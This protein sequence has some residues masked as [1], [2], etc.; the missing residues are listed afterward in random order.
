[1]SLLC[2]GGQLLCIST[3][4]LSGPKQLHQAQFIVSPS[5]RHLFTCSRHFCAAASN[6]LQQAWV[7][8]SPST[9]KKLPF[10]YKLRLSWKE[11]AHLLFDLLLYRIHPFCLRIL[12]FVSSTSKV[13]QD[14]VPTIVQQDVFNL[15]ASQTNTESLRGKKKA[16]NICFL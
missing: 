1:M 5:P 9:T 15:K 3:L 13:T 10:K 2:Q 14:I 8:F 16:T 11:K 12:E 4:S 6:L 7:K